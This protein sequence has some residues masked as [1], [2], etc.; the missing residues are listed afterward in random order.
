MATGGPGTCDGFSDYTG[1]GSGGA[2]RVVAN[3]I[4][5]SSGIHPEEN[6]FIVE[7]GLPNP[8]YS[9]PGYFFLKAFE[10]AST[11]QASDRQGGGCHTRACRNP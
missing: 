1:N 11:G 3:R 2:M 9:Y 6:P 4:D 7:L 10:I 8:L 5:G